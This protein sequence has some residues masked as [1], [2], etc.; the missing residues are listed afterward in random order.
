VTIPTDPT[1]RTYIP[2]AEAFSHEGDVLDEQMASR[3]YP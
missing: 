3:K 1:E 2:G